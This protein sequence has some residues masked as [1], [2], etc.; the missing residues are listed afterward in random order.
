MKE[1]IRAR[2]NAE[3][4]KLGIL[5]LIGTLYAVW[6]RLTGIGIPCIINLLFGVKCPGCGITH[7]AVALTHFDFAGAFE[8]NKL[9][10]TVVPI[11]LILLAVEEVRYIKTS[12]RKFTLF[13]IIILTILLIVTIAYGI[14]RNIWP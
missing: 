8:Y 1:E 13:E 6:W 4:K 7:A 12:V 11:L 14:G 5:L 2:R 9:S 10:V 3:L